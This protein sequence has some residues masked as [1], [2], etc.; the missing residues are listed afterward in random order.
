M[1]LLCRF[2]ICPGGECCAGRLVGEAGVSGV[3][4]DRL[5]EGNGI[6]DSH[7]GTFPR[8]PSGRRRGIPGAGEG[9]SQAQ[10]AVRH[11]A[12]SKKEKSIGLYCFM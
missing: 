12:S 8:F 5:G 9:L 10:A 2:G 4:C 1:G 3:L 7:G 6:A 11:R